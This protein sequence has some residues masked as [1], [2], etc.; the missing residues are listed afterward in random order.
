MPSFGIRQRV[1]QNRVNL[2]LYLSALSA[3]GMNDFLHELGQAKEL[4]NKVCRSLG[5]Y[6]Q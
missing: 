4:L 3:E 1:R 5:A 6:N 2:D